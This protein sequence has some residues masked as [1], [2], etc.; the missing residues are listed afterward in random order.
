M[1]KKK[2]LIIFFTII[3][4]ILLLFIIHTIRNFTIIN[5]LQREAEK[6]IANTNYHYQGIKEDN[7][8]VMVTT[9]IYKKG[10]KEAYFME[11]NDNGTI[12]KVL[13][14]NNGERLDVFTEKNNLKT[15]KLN[16]N[17][18]VANSGLINYFENDCSSLYKIIYSMSARIKTEEINGV[19]CYVFK[20]YQNS[21][22]IEDNEMYVNKDT[23]LCIK[24]ITSDEKNEYKY[25]FDNVDDSIFAEPDIS[26]YTLE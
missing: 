14:Y 10:D 5:K 4:I 22:Y 24:C 18:N 16:V 12:T 13:M 3:L 20:N 9:D 26:Q 21:Q 25:E 23:G 1:N 6:N 19:E 7:N 17:S 2:M 8:G 15:A 11:K